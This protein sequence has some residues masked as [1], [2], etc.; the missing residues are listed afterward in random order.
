MWRIDGDDK[1][2]EDLRHA[3][4]ALGVV[5]VNSSEGGAVARR[6]FVVVIL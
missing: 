2:H 3:R 4:T 1:P 6:P 5:A